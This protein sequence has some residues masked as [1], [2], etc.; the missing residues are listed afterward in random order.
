MS[1][2]RPT[3]DSL[4]FSCDRCSELEEFNVVDDCPTDDDGRSEFGA[5]LDLARE[6]GWIVFRT[7]DP[8][9]EWGHLCP[10]CGEK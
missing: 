5:C 6:D 10:A 9:D 7:G 2:D 3:R 4:V 1:A 8:R